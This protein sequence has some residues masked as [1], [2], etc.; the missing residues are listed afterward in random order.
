[1]EIIIHDNRKIAEIQEEFS[2]MFPY[3]KLHFFGKPH[4]ANG[5]GIKKPMLDPSK[6]IGQCREKHLTGVL[7]IVPQMTVT[8]LKKGFKENFGLSVQVFRKVGD[9]WLETVTEIWPLEKHNTHITEANS[10]NTLEVV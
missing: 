1:M 6:T 7:S 2:R 10:E 8:D 9:D 3:L 5:N 4:K